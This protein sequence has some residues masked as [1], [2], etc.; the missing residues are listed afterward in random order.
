[1]I[2]A[3]LRALRAPEPSHI[4][5][6]HDDT[7]FTVVLRRSPKAR[8]YTLRVC[9]GSGEI[10]L[11]LPA[12]ADLRAA[13]DFA[14]RNSGWIAGRL[15]R[16]P[17]RV[18]LDHGAMVP[19]RGVIHRIEHRPGMRGTV[20]PEFDE[21]GSPVL[22]VAGSV[23][24]VRRRVIDFLK[25]E[26]ARDLKTAVARHAAALE[27]A[28]TGVTLRDTRSR[29]GSCSATGRLN[30]SWRLVM[31]PPFVLD[32]LAAHEAVHRREMNHSNRFWR[33]LRE[34][35]P[36]TDEAESWLDRNGAGL[37]RYR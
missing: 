37:H 14:L 17:D 35:C 34:I 25:R 6:P 32:Y 13:S 36:A 22:A 33:L 30:F 29:W 20:R 9:S 31:A 23:E 8:R 4:L 24:H 26:A 28:V 18:T 21:A 1:M 5:V 15:A 10:V 12:R 16:L 2:L 27:V 7:E 3:R 11:T 19:F